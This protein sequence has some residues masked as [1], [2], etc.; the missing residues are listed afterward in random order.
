VMAVAFVTNGIFAYRYALPCVMGFALAIAVI[1]LRSDR[2]K[3][4]L[5]MG[6]FTVFAVI[7]VGL[8]G[9]HLRHFVV[10]HEPPKAERL[11]G[12]LADQRQRV[13]IG[14][15][16]QYLELVYYAPA[17]MRSRLFY[18]A[19]PAYAR[20][21]LSFDDDDRSLLLLRH[22]APLQVAEY[23]S[24]MKENSTFLLYGGPADG[25]LI[26]KFRAEQ[27]SVPRS[28]PIGEKMLQLIGAP[29]VPPV[30]IPLSED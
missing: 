26:P 12:I 6:Y 2:A 16:H 4:A 10:D 25:W 29:A 20:R 1:P 5:G 14:D 11:A 18:I 30:E 24:F 8:E 17:E 21:F 15:P 7:F 9:W 13:V 22:W 3:A 19:S 23:E 27:A 28:R